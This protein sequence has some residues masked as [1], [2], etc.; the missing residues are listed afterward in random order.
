MNPTL[1]KKAQIL[2][3]TTFTFKCQTCDKTFHHGNIKDYLEIMKKGNPDYMIVGIRHAWDNP[4]HQIKI[5]TENEALARGLI[6]NNLFLNQ[7]V[8]IVKENNPG[9]ANRPFD[10][11]RMGFPDQ[12][13]KIGIVIC[14]TCRKSHGPTPYSWKEAADCCKET[15][16]FQG[17]IP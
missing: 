14:S 15:K 9:K 12:N 13:G 7:C 17:E 8:K 5:E 10:S 16:L 6:Q 2:T 3:Q 4:D 1:Q 11:L